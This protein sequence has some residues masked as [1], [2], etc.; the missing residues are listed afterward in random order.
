MRCFQFHAMISV[1]GKPENRNFGN[2]EG[3]SQRVARADMKLVRSGRFESGGFF[4]LRAVFL[5][6]FHSDLFLFLCNKEKMQRPETTFIPFFHSTFNPPTSIHV[7]AGPRKESH[8][9]AYRCAQRVGAKFGTLAERVT[10]HRCYPFQKALNAST[11][12]KRVP[13]CQRQP[14]TLRTQ[15]RNSIQPTARGRHT[16]RALS[17]SLITLYPIRLKK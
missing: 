5:H 1:P 15:N 7:H 17:L 3:A 8:S 9:R 4:G 13:A 12:I 11:C 10:L 14:R 2:S 6:P 16:W